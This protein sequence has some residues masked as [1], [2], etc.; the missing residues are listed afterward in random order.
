MR[1]RV[2]IGILAAVTAGVLL[3]ARTYRTP[4][5][6]RSPGRP[7]AE[8]R[9][10]RIVSL[11]PSITEVLFALGVG[12][13]VVGVTRFCDYPEGARSLP[14]VGG[15]FDPNYEAIIA[16][17]P[18]LIMNIGIQVIS[19]LE[20]AHEAGVVHRDIK[21]ANLILTPKGTIKVADFGIAKIE[22]ANHTQDGALLGSPQYMAPEQVYAVMVD[23][24]ADLFSLGVVLYQLTTGRLPFS[25]ASPTETIEQITH[26]QPEAVARFNYDCPAEPERI[27]RKCLE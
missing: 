22:G 12:E 18:D 7:V 1:S 4:R 23:H 8:R 20:A 24:R 27:L 10:R 26:A 11:A 9:C 13:R 16:L 21:P 17:E 6:H 25:G 19:A 3:A 2:V 14:K 15:H 5:R